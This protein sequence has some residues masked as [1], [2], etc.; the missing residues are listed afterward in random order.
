MPGSAVVLAGG[1]LAGPGALDGV[2]A[3]APVESTEVA[4][5]GRT[6]DLGAK[7]GVGAASA[8]PQNPQNLLPVG[9]GFRH[10]G[11][12][13]C[14]GELGGAAGRC[15]CAGPCSGLPQRAQVDSVAG[16]GVPHDG[17]RR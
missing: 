6:G 17:Q 2:W 9:K 11:Q 15:A 14:P 10:F 1:V 12:V 8:A 7:S 4:A 13:T 16:L 5:A 3:G